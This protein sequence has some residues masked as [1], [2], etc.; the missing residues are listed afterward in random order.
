MVELSRTKTKLGRVKYP[1][2]TLRMS[3][4][5]E[6]QPRPSLSA[7]PHNPAFPLFRIKGGSKGY[8]ILRGSATKY[9][10]SGKWRC[11][12]NDAKGWVRLRCLE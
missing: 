1:T 9:P 5:R 2:D 6:P 12:L 11:N 10:N 8:N 4:L 7:S 3:A